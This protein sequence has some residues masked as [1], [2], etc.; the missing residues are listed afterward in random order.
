MEQFTCSFRDVL[1]DG[2]AWLEFVF[3][4]SSVL[5]LTVYHVHLFFQIQNSPL[6]TSVGLT[7]R[8]RSDW[9]RTMM[10][11]RM[12]IVAVQTLRN[13]T[14][15]ASFLASTA[16]FINMGIMNTAFQAE[17]VP[18]IAHTLNFLGSTC[19]RLWL[20]KLMVLIVELFFAFFNFSL[21]VR[22]Y[23]HASL[24]INVPVEQD[25]LN[26][27]EAVVATL[28]RGALHYMLGMRGYYLAIPFTLW[29]FG[30]TWMLGGTVIMIAVLYKLDRIA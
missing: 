1:T 30:P 25:P 19:H 13:W 27:P 4:F 3:I 2:K 20:F 26:T 18:E 6:K 22:Y 16:I 8:L 24:M 11:G 21:S 12:D 7:N 10:Q 14:M 9:V 17:R 15:A 5:M 23:N 29:L 28:N